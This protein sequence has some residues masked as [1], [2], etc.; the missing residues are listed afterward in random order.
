[1]LIEVSLG[2]G[3]RASTADE[4]KISRGEV[5]RGG[6]ASGGAGVTL[7]WLPTSVSCVNSQSDV[8]CLSLM[9]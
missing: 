5:G 6:V 8:G 1:M 2:Q 3:K 4:R 7:Q 9:S